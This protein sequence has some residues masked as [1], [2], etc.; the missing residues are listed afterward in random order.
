MELEKVLASLATGELISAKAAGNRLPHDPGL[1]A[2]IIDDPHSFPESFTAHLR[3]QKN[4]LI[5]LGKTT[6]SLYKRLWEQDFR[7]K[8]P[9]TFFRAIGPILGYRPPKGSLAGKANKNNYKFSP[10]DTQAIIGW[11]TE[12]L[13]IRYVVMPSGEATLLEPSVISALRPLLNTQHNPNA[14]PDIARLREECRKIAIS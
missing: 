4:N 11:I 9:S 14:L 3:E 10:A 5:Y 8:S 2:I 13:S 7:H 1:Y 12:H 6:D